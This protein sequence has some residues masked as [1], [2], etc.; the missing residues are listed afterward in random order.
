V[1]EPDVPVLE[2]PTGRA[3]DISHLLPAAFAT[4][5]PRAAASRAGRTLA[6][7][8]LAIAGTPDATRAVEAV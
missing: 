3:F 5:M 8:T 4:V 6:K 1:D 2:E 7:A